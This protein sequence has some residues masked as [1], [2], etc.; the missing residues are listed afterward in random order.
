MSVVLQDRRA[1]GRQFVGGLGASDIVI[2]TNTADR[3]IGVECDGDT[4]QGDR[5]PNCSNMAHMDGARLPSEI[6]RNAR[7]RYGWKYKRINGRMYDLCRWHA[8]KYRG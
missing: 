3:M 6:R 2:L 4:A 8:Q 5:Y 1:A 7:E